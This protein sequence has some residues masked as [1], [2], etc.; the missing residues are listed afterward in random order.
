MLLGVHAYDSNTREARR[1][2]GHEFKASQ[3]YITRLSLKRM[4]QKAKSKDE[5]LSLRGW[6]VRKAVVALGQVFL[7]LCFDLSLCSLATA[8]PSRIRRGLQQPL[9]LW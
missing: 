8:L 6:V 9:S 2:E 4:K 7:C 3:G 5:S 1:E